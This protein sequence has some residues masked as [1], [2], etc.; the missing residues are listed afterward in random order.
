MFAKEAQQRRPDEESK[1]AG[2]RHDAHAFRR[3]RAGI[4]GGGNGKRETERRAES[5]QQYR[6]PGNPGA[7]DKNNQPIPSAPITALART[8]VTRL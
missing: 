7:V 8:T 4:A 1:I 3:I 5:P 2:N 6:Y